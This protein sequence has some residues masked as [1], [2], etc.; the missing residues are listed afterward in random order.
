[1]INYG[2]MDY[3]ANQKS[4]RE[5]GENTRCCYITSKLTV[6][7]EDYL[8]RYAEGTFENI[9]SKELPPQGVELRG[10]LISKNLAVYELTMPVE[11]L[12]FFMEIIHEME[13]LNSDKYPFIIE[14][15][16]IVHH[17][18]WDDTIV[19]HYTWDTPERREYL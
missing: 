6:R 4:L 12:P 11:V 2:Y 7:Y 8:G 5:I 18:T 15:D 17:Y 16:T 13:Y 1:M 9:L 19:H 14:S 3:L 10:E